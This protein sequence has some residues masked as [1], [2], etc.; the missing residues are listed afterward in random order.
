MWN[1]WI[2]FYFYFEEAKWKKIFNCWWG[3]EKKTKQ[4]KKLTAEISHKIETV[5]Q[6]QKVELMAH[7]KLVFRSILFEAI[8]F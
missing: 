4:I 5:Q 2:M 3:R 1:E 8:T 7:R 6:Q